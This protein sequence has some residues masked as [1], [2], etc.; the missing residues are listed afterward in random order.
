MY[1]P[2]YL[3]LVIMILLMGFVK[4]NP[5]Y[6]HLINTMVIWTFSL[7]FRTMDLPICLYTH[8]LG[9]HFM[10]HL[11]NAIVLYR[12][13]VLIIMDRLAKKNDLI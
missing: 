4:Q 5:L 3:M 2:T 10:W 9:T 7:A 6:L 12:M 11:L 8:H 13:L 1:V